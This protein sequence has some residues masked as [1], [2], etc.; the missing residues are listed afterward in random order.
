MFYHIM[1]LD[2]TT[3]IIAAVDLDLSQGIGEDFHF[4]R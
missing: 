4:A 3:S 2:T 1:I